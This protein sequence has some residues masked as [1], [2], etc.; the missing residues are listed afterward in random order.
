[1]ETDALNSEEIEAGREG[2]E[3]E[4]GSDKAEIS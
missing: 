1:M 2:A 4:E 3:Q